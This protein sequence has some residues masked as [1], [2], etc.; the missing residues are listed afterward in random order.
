MAGRRRPLPDTAAAM[1]LENRVS[2]QFAGGLV[3]GPSGGN[4]V[5]GGER[6]AQEIVDDI[7]VR[8]R[9]VGEVLGT[10]PELMAA[11]GVSRGTFREAVRILEHLG[12]AGCGRAV[13]VGSWSPRPSPPGDQAAAVYLRYRGVDTSSLHSAGAPSRSAWSSV[14]PPACHPRWR[15]SSSASARNRS[16]SSIRR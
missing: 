3:T 6:V 12:C 4:P 14:S 2:T 5:K 11:Y 1:K 16:S 13:A 10:E 15:M 9:P 8:G 7:A